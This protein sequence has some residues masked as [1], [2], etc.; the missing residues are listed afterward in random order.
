[1]AALAAK[2]GGPDPPPGIDKA[3]AMLNEGKTADAEKI[4]AGILKRKQ[5]EGTAALKEAAEAARHLGA[6]A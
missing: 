4:F 5:A 1:V 6:L 2:A 3:L